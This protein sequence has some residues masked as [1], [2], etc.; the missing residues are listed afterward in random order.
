M[1]YLRSWPIMKNAKF[2]TRITIYDLQR[3]STRCMLVLTVLLAAALGCFAQAPA[4]HSLTELLSATGGAFRETPGTGTASEGAP[5]AVTLQ[6]AISRAHKIYSQYLAT[7]TDAQVA[8][9]DF[10]QARNAMLPSIGYTH[11][12]LGTQ[13]N[14]KTPNGRY[15]TNDGVHVYR[16]W[17]VFHQDVPAGFFSAA[18]YKRAAA[19][20]A[21]A[22]AKAEIA[23]RGLVVTVTKAFYTL[24]AAQRKYASAQQT[25]THAQ[26]FL[27]DTRKLE[28]GGEVAH[29]DAVKAQLQLDQQKIALQEAELAMNNAH[30]ALTVLISQTFDQNF[31]AVDDMN[32]AP[33]LPGLPELKDLAARGNQDIRAALQ[34]LRQAKADV[35]IA[36]AG[37]FPTLA[38]DADYGIEANALA[39]HSK[40]A[41]MPEAGVLPNLGYFVTA[42]LNVPIWNWGTTRS[43]LQQAYYR[44]RQAEVDLSQT[45]REALNN[46]YSFYNEATAAQSETQTLREAADLAAQSL[47]LT[48]LRYQA[49]EA[50][51]LEI[52]DAQNA[53]TTARN[54]FDD[55]QARYWVAL[56]TLQTLTGRF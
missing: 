8:R 19:S 24:I 34:A 41:A 13:G 14:G 12:Y 51:A 4:Q 15:V 7:V 18:S 43:K 36:R 49:G 44:R 55:G 42:S 22:D 37:F 50:T 38:V 52:V 9:E 1:S 11:Q 10:R 3:L 25:V 29:A 27:D 46:L 21:L 48:N 16:A 5:P 56:A 40:M 28:S 47:R 31:T 6:D 45:Q 54:A 53:L 30:L 32:N 2:G 26:R 20:A 17:G 35:T 23:R 39:L 33:V